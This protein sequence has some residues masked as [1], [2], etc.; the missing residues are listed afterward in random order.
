[1]LFPLPA[2]RGCG[3]LS[4][5]RPGTPGGAYQALVAWRS[6]GHP[7]GCFGLVSVLLT[8]EAECRV[9]PGLSGE[10]VVAALLAGLAGRRA[11]YRF[12]SVGYSDL[13]DAAEL[14]TEAPALPAR[15]RRASFRCLGPLYSGAAPPGPILRSPLTPSGP[16]AW[17]ASVP[18]YWPCVF[19][20][21][22]CPGF[23]PGPCKVV[24]PAGS[25][26][27]NVSRNIVS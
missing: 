14:P 1:M 26:G 16:A 9:H 5:L 27:A 24:A 3:A 7:A 12:V 18:C 11:A 20:H 17:L 25:A 15:P 19:S 13:G 10:A 4:G 21:P 2:T 23:L 22:G 8:P 6:N